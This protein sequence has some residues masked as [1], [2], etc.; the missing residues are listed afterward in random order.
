MSAELNALRLRC[1]QPPRL[2]TAFRPLGTTLA[3]LRR[4]VATIV[5][6]ERVDGSSNQRTGMLTLHVYTAASKHSFSG[7]FVY[8]PMVDNASIP[9]TG[10]GLSRGIG[11]IAAASLQRNKAMTA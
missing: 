5:A 2:L 6:H 9:S 7:G 11:Y 8:T 1:G 4:L 3:Q 10:G